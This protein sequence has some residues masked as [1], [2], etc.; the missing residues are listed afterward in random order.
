MIIDDFYKCIKVFNKYLDIR[1]S[2]EK[3]ENKLSYSISKYYELYVNNTYICTFELIDET[4]GLIKTDNDTH[5]VKDLN[6]ILEVLEN[7]ISK[8][9]KNIKNKLDPVIM[10]LYTE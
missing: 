9:P 7:Y 3:I 4:I 1:C 5:M 8:L 2:V 6:D 10:E